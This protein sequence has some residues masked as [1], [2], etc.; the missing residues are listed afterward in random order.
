MA[1]SYIE[2]FLCP[3]LAALLAICH[4]SDLPP[5]L[6]SLNRHHTNIKFTYELEKSDNMPFSNVQFIRK[7]GKCSSFSTLIFQHSLGSIA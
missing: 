1:R 4:L 2:T 3:V 5:G 7:M 6:A